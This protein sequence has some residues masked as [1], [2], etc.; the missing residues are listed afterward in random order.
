MNHI[1]RELLQVA[2]S[3]T[4]SLE[5]PSLDGMTKR[6]ATRK[7]ND[8]L[9]KNSK[10]IFSDESWVP[11]NKIWNEL[12]ADG[13]DFNTTGAEYL[14][15]EHGVSTG[16]QWKFQVSFINEKGRNTILYGTVT[17]SGCGSVESPLS[18]YDLVSYCS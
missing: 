3:L 6:Q 1:A 9:S 15:N 5:S 12:R 8:I 17:A 14:K 4:A 13:I 7:V 18:R 10:G 16:K 2:R 11:V